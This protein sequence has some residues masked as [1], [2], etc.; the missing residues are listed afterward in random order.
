MHFIFSGWLGDDI[1]E[2][3]PCFIITDDLKKWIE[4][5]QLSGYKFQEVEVS[6][7]DEFVELYSNREIP[8]FKRLIP[9]SSVVVEDKTY[10][11][12]S[13]GDFS[14]SDKSYLVV[15]EKALDILNEYNIDNCDLYELNFKIDT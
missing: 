14:L 8:E 4:K 6:L 7:S 15:S 13:G 2:S 3:T 5:S 11:K 10:T 1:I 12:W 9:N